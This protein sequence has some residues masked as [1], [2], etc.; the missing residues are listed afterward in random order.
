VL[1]K[2]NMLAYSYRM[3]PEIS[4]SC[5]VFSRRYSVLITPRECARD[6]VIGRIVVVV[7]ST[8]IDTSRDLG[9]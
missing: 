7:V 8:K 6:K 1:I 3:L 5:T 4:P 2:Y 9:I